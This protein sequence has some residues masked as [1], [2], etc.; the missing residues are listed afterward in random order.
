MP[1]LTE[2]HTRSRVVALSRPICLEDCE[3]EHVGR[4]L[5]QSRTRARLKE[6]GVQFA[7]VR[8]LTKQR[9]WHCRRLHQDDTCYA[10]L[11][12][13]S[14]ESIAMSTICCHGLSEYL[15]QA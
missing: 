3:T 8:N 14:N 7:S 9:S 6:A 5:E 2:P 12:R 11:D 10:R 15:A 4:Y 1:V 13:S